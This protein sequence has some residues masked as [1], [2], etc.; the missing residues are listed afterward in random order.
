MRPS[1]NQ[2]EPRA[3]QVTDCWFDEPLPGDRG[4]WAV[5]SGHGIYRGLDLELLNPADEDER[6]FLIEAQHPELDGALRNDE[7]MI[8]GSEPF[9]PRLHI[10]L[11]QIVASQLLV[12]D[13]PVA[14][15]VSLWLGTQARARRATARQCGSRSRQ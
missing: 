15:S 7:E 10:T 6:T 12:G 13:P 14:G 11:H 4:S 8:V 2:P 9:S 1:G 5:L 3:G